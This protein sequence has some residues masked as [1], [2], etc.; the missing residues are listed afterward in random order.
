M[1]VTLKATD[2]ASGVA[3]TEYRADDESTWTRGD[4]VSFMPLETRV[5]HTLV[6]PL[7]RQHRQRGEHPDVLREDRGVPPESLAPNT[8]ASS[9]TSKWNSAW[10]NE[11]VVVTLTAEDPSGVAFTEHSVDG[12]AWKRGTEVAIPAPGDHSNDGR[13]TLAYRSE[14]TRGDLE[15]SKTAKIAIDTAP[16]AT[17]ATGGGTSWHNHDVTVRLTAT[18]LRSGV[19]ESPSTRSTAARPG[20][21]TAGFSSPPSGTTATTA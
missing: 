18:D 4:S 12:G 13:H 10:Q 6:L 2:G 9:T 5:T 3:Y 19:A 21:R 1:T 14:D 11:A 17:T 8:T 15:V 7:G 16:P 20:C